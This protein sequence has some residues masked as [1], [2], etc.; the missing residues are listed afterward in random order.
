MNSFLIVL[1]LNVIRIDSKPMFAE[2]YRCNHEHLNKIQ[3]KK[4]NENIEYYLR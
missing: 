1:Q 4:T 2:I 3:L